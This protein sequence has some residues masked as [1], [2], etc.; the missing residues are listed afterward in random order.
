[1]HEVFTQKRLGLLETSAAL[2][3]NGHE[4]A[5]EVWNNAAGAMKGLLWAGRAGHS[6]RP[7]DQLSFVSGGGGG[8]EA[9][10]PNWRLPTHLYTR[11]A[12]LFCCLV[13]GSA[14]S[15]RTCPNKSFVPF[16]AFSTEH[17]SAAPFQ[18]QD[19]QL[20]FQ[21]KNRHY[22]S[23]CSKT[24]AL[25]LQPCFLFSKTW[26]LVWSASFFFFIFRSNF[27]VLIF[28]TI[29]KELMITAPPLLWRR[30]PIA[31]TAPACPCGRHLCCGSS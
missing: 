6:E 10:A 18:L 24:S 28:S 30:P 17:I 15:E 1:M 13:E 5:A 7:A 2:C 27:C 23:F 22:F 9:V 26:R 29:Q 14:L 4:G 31:T 3:L 11:T 19:L 25:N 8:G 12:L 21:N 16:F 20:Q